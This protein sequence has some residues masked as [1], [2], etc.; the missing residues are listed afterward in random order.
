MDRHT[1]LTA[2]DEQ[3]RRHPQPATPDE[4]IEH[5]PNVVRIVADGD[6][7]TG[8]IWSDLDQAS[9][10][11]VIAAQIRRFAHLRRSWEW[12]HY[13]YDQPP[14]LPDRLLAAGFTPEPGRGPARRRDR[15]PP[16]RGATTAGRGGAGS[17]R[18]ARGRGAGGGAS[19]SW[20][21]RPRSSTPA[22]QADLPV[23]APTATGRGSRAVSTTRP[24]RHWVWG[25]VG[26]TRAPS[27]QDRSDRPVPRGLTAR[28]G[29]LCQSRGRRPGHGHGCGA[30]R[31]DGAVW[32]G[33]LP[34]VA[35]N[36]PRTPSWHSAAISAGNGAASR[37]SNW[38]AAQGQTGSRGRW[39]SAGRRAAGSASAAWS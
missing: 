28:E 25:P 10:D 7:W 38:Q 3:L 29:T 9:A 26:V 11:A 35:S 1:L 12:K 23:V 4:R 39:S 22:D 6:G 31:P 27:R 33:I 14:D 36:R 20:P 32:R 17:H 16:P 2:F 5:D 24:R 15:R 34:R 18:P 13:S 8:V 19:S 30:D 37:R 21:P